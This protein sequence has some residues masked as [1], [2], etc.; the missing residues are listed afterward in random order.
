MGDMSGGNA[1][2]NIH[3][4]YQHD[5][6]LNNGD[7]SIGNGFINIHT[8]YQCNNSSDLRIWMLMLKMVMSM[9]DII[10]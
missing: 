10:I 2:M 3:T 5:W 4:L 8:I 7:V 1:F 9:V 6:D